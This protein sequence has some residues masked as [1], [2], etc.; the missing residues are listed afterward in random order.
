M[1][2]RKLSAWLPRASAGSRVPAAERVTLCGGAVANCVAHRAGSARCESGSNT[3]EGCQPLAGI[4]RVDKSPRS[5][6]WVQR[7]YWIGVP[8]CVVS[9]M[10]SVAASVKT[11]P[12]VFV[13][14][15]R[16]LVSVGSAFAK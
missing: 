15:K 14:K 6:A 12:D 10:A 3:H 7:A 11:V 1:H 4:L 9:V 8:E 5:G 16:M 2:A 13:P